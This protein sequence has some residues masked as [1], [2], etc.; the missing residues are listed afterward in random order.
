MH[1]GGPL[2]RPYDPSP[3]LMLDRPRSLLPARHGRYHK[4]LQKRYD[5]LHDAFDELGIEVMLEDY[6]HGQ[7]KSAVIRL[8]K[9]T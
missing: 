2:W 8:Y 1:D 4:N 5:H 9:Q 7:R 3:G 6:H